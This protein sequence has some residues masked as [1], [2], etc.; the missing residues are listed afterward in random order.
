MNE[1]EAHL[2]GIVCEAIRPNEIKVI[3]ELFLGFVLLLLDFLQ[4][5]LK[6]HRIRND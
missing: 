3:L 1:R 5:C 6:I 4:H 2:C